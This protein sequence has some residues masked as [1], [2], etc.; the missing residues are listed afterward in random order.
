MSALLDIYGVG[1][2]G[3]PSLDAEPEQPTLRRRKD[4]R[5]YQRIFVNKIKRIPQIILALPMGSGKTA[6][7]LT[8]ILDLLDDGEVKRVLIVAPLLVAAATW[9]DEF[10]EWEH[11]RDLEWT[12][13]RAEDGDP[14]IVAAKKD[15]YDVARNLIGLTPKEAQRFAGRHS[16]VAKEWKRAKLA[17]TDTEI[18]IINREALPWLW[19]FFGKGKLWP[20]DMLVVD[21][22]SMFKNAKMRTPKKQLTR[23]GVMAK[24]RKH[25]KRIALLTGTPAPKGLQNLW[26]LAYIADGGER[27]G[28]NKHFFDQRWF[29][30]DYMGWNIEPKRHAKRQITDR[31]SD[32]MFSL[33][34]KDCVDLP[35]MNPV[36]V[37][38]SLPRRVLEEY[39]EFERTLYSEQYDIEA[40]NKGVLHGK[41]LQFANGSMYNEDRQPIWIHDEKL[42]ALEQIIEDAN[43]APVLV[44]YSFEFD[45]TRIKKVF[46]K[47]TVFGRGGDVRKQKAS[48]NRGEIDL[49]L[50][51]PA[52]VG[53]GQNIQYGGNIS[54][55]YGLTPD[56]E[57]YQQFNKRLHRS[58]QELPVWNHHILARGTYDEKL[59]PLLT[60]RDA[61]QA[62]IIE[63][64]RVKMN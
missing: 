57:L 16:T 54:I 26:G 53:H 15:S 21:E 41:L 12:L 27:L 39:R 50:A 10:E 11:T 24:A 55:W 40:V 22:A 31:L 64:V 62:E 63:S 38:V 52:S 44:A 25:A 5:R 42:E 60:K 8:A 13:I 6:T 36:E 20:Y 3:G 56:L 2:N 59:I 7:T 19:E 17:N 9:P 14:E 47:A 30:K 32:I 58:G 4:L 49:M 23:F 61:N 1:H 51:H 35:P 29:E 48:W 37:K 18:H 45:L 28:D 43:G 46:K 33:D 34:E